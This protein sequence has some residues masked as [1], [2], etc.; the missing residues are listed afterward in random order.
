MLSEELKNIAK[1]YQKS[2]EYFKEISELE[3]NGK[4]YKEIGFYKRGLSLFGSEVLGYIFVDN[5]NNVLNSQNV[6]KELC[7]LAHYNEAFFSTEKG[8]GILAALKNKDDVISERLEVDPI[9]SGLDFLRDNGVLGT[10]KI[11]YVVKK[12]P[13]AKE[14]IDKKTEVFAEVINKYRDKIFNEES[15]KL[16]YPY[17]E[18]ILKLNFENVKLI[19]TVADVCQDVQV[20][21]EKTR[22]K[23]AIRAKKNV[24][25]QLIRTSDKIVYFKKVI[26]TYNDVIDMSTSQYVKFLNNMNKDKIENRARL[27]RG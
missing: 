15:L 22:K 20:A 18:E 12:L 8:K 3:F 11:K 2:G 4:T 16:I 24:V 26:R 13:D 10:E 9:S 27:V 6:I 7:K 23:W 25:G 1:T 21:A 5:D 14:V 17:Y 19:A